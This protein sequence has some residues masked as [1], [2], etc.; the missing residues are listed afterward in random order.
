MLAHGIPTVALPRV[1]AGIDRLPWP[2]VEGVLYEIFGNSQV[3]AI[4][5]IWEG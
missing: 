4:V 1:G 3:N 2:E 5:H